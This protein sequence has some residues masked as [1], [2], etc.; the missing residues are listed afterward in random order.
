MR[1]ETR[2]KGGLHFHQTSRVWWVA[3]KFEPE[4]F[5]GAGFEVDL[6]VAG[7]GTFARGGFEVDLAVAGAG[8]FSRGGFEVGLVVAGAGTFPRGGF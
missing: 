5:V 3:E 8:T 2:G 7:E 1:G 6:A 4:T